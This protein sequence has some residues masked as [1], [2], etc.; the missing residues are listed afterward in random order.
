MRPPKSHLRQNIESIALALVVALLVRS[1]VVEAFWVPSGSM[2]PTIQIGD[3]LFV[4]KLAYAVRVPLLGT[5]LF[6]TG[7]VQRGEIVVF[8]SPVD[9]QDLIK[10]VVAI[11]GDTVEI[12]DKRLLVNGQAAADTYAQF[13]DRH[14]KDAPRD[15]YGPAVVPA[16]KFFVLGDNRDQSYDSRYW[17]FADVEEIKGR[18]MFIYFSWDTK[19]CWP[20]WTHLQC[21]PRWGRLG[22]VLR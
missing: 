17:G 1:S 9:G 7:S 12:R 11:A 6:N 3:Q 22:H 18:A 13:S 5:K 16:G 4:N 15:R 14:H 10:R 20:S 21:G 8:V 2:L 19:N